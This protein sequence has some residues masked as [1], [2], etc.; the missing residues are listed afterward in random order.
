MT[1]FSLTL[2]PTYFWQWLCL[3]GFWPHHDSL[4]MA[5]GEAFSLACRQF[6]GV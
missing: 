5:K 3:E 6:T 4:A 1:I 2:D